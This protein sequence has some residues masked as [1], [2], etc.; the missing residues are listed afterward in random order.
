VGNATYRGEQLLMWYPRDQTAVLI[1][2]LGMYH[3]F[4]NSL[5]SSLPDFT[6]LAAS[7]LANRRPAEVLFLSTT[8]AQFGA[9][10][11]AL[12]TYRP[13]LLRTTVMRRGPAVLHA[14]LI[15]L[16]SFARPAA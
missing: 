1:G 8:G 6:P 4:F 10:L 16:R 5:A 3:D 9:A 14:W 15:L 13:V 2:P 12:T 11:N 7:I